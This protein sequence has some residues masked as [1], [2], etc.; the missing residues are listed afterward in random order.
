[1]VWEIHFFSQLVTLKIR[2]FP[3][4]FA[5][6][7]AQGFTT[8]SSP[9]KM[10]RSINQLSHEKKTALL[11]MKYVLLKKRYSYVM[12]YINNPHITG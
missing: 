11:S 4:E 6:F 12:V 2:I 9:P 7:V 1:M 10:M 3:A 8:H 5:F